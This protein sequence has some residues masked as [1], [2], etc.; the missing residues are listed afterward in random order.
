MDYF[1]EIDTKCCEILCRHF[2][3]AVVDGRDIRQ[4]SGADLKNYQH[5]HLFAGIGGFGEGFKGSN[6]NG[7]IITGGFP[8]QD[9]SVAGKRAGLAGERSGL[10]FEF[11]RIIGEV[12]P[13]WVVVENVPG[14]LSSNGGDDFRTILQGLEKFGYG[15]AWRVLDAQYFGLAQRRKRVFIVASFGDG[16]CA[17]VLFEREGVCWNPPPC[18]EAGKAVTGSSSSVFGIDS[19]QN[20]VEDGIGT[21]RSHKSGGAEL[22]AFD[23]R[24]GNDTGDIGISLQGGAGGRGFSLNTQPIV[25][26]GGGNKDE[27]EVST[28]ISTKSGTRQ[29]YESDTFVV[30]DEQQVTS[31]ANRSTGSVDHAYTLNQKGKMMVLNTND[32]GSAGNRIQM[33]ADVGVTLQGNGGGMAAKTGMYLLPSGVRRLTP[34]ECE[35]LQG[36][37][38]GWTVGQSDSV[39][40]RQLG[41]A[42]AVPVIRWLRER[43]E[44]VEQE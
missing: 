28:S 37:P 21:L 34:V 11:E 38:D 9:L 14:L 42:V 25:A 43:I 13:R 22:F 44:G 17:K 7:Q 31:K 32:M 4:V 36:F 8:C 27:I 1:N 29:D 6:I 10:W 41:N 12:L 26:F 23:A 24:N 35:R 18:R 33:D 16:S 39:R 15:V 20:A 2:P 40:Y 3:D 19:E 5:I 30:Y